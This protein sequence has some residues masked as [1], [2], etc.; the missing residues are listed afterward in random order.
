MPGLDA[1]ESI[2]RRACA[3]GQT[4]SETAVVFQTLLSQLRRARPSFSIRAGAHVLVIAPTGATSSRMLSASLH[5]RYDQIQ[6]VT[7]LLGGVATFRSEA[8]GF[9]VAQVHDVTLA[10]GDPF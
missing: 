2:F 8:V 1:L 4:P 3:E 10:P 6:H 5:L 9:I 7:A